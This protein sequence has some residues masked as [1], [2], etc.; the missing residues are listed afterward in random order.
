M[1]AEKANALNLRS[2]KVNRAHTSH[3]SHI[4]RSRRHHLTP[5]RPQTHG[6]GDS[7]SPPNLVEDQDQPSLDD[8][9][10]SD[11]HRSVNDKDE[12]DPVCSSAQGQSLSTHDVAPCSDGNAEVTLADSVALAMEN[13]YDDKW[14][15]H[16]P[17]ERRYCDI[18]DEN[19][20]LCCF[21][22]TWVSPWNFDDP[23]VASS[24]L[25]EL[26]NIN[27]QNPQK[28]WSLRVGCDVPELLDHISCV[29]ARGTR[30]GMSVYFAHWKDQWFREKN[31]GKRER[32]TAVSAVERQN[33]FACHDS[34]STSLRSKKV[35]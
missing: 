20:Y 32:L 29:T 33:A 34:R 15:Y 35:S 28:P 30:G 8:M 26:Y 12:A 1:A 19:E 7:R 5:T 6:E 23:E 13:T 11:M 21:D 25:E 4:A 31:V 24:K 3:R 18:H 14:N 16:G 27:Q 9:R 10:E 17:V 22:P 2:R